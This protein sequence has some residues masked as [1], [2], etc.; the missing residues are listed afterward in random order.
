[1]Y[2]LGRNARYSAGLEVGQNIKIWGRIQSREYQK[3]WI[4]RSCNKVAFEVSVSKMEVCDKINRKVEPKEEQEEKQEERQ[5][6][7]TEAMKN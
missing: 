3:S 2:L 4:R 7:K 5:E 1:V 6:E